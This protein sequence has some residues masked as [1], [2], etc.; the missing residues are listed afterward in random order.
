MV[1]DLLEVKKI[2]NIIGRKNFLLTQIRNSEK[3]KVFAKK[4]TLNNIFKL[5]IFLKVLRI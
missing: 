4:Y 2:E 1:S 3:G 5:E